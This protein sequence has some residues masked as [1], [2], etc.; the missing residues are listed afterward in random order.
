MSISRHRSTSLYLDRALYSRYTL[1][2]KLYLDIERCIH[3]Y[4]SIRY[5]A[6]CVRY[7]ARCVHYLAYCV[8]YLARCVR[9][10]VRRPQ[11]LHVNHFRNLFHISK[12]VSHVPPQQRAPHC[13]CLLLSL[14]SMPYIQFFFKK[15][16]RN[17]L[18]TC[19]L[20]SAHHTARV[21][22]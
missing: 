13:A 2:L 1:Y 22:Y 4:I 10:L 19:L 5:L 7:L 14:A 17:L 21:L 6:R 9:H 12:F 15:N 3:V 16:S 11:R 8:R 20:S 18:C